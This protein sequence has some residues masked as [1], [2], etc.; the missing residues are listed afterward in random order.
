LFGK[1]MASNIHPIMWEYYNLAYQRRPEFMGWSQ[2][3]PTTKTNYSTF[4][5][6]NFGDE[7]QKRIHQ[8]QLIEYKVKALRKQIQAKDSDAFYQLVYYPVVGASYMNKKF[9]YRDKAYLYSKQNRLSALTYSAMSKVAYD[10]IVAETTYF[11]TQLR[12]GKWKHMMSMQPRKLPVFLEPELPVITMDRKA[13]WD[14]LP[15]GYD[16][17]YNPE[18]VNLKLPLFDNLNKQQY[19]I[20]LFLCDSITINWSAH[21][22]DPWIKVSTYS[23]ILNP[24]NGRSESRIWISV[25]W[26]KI[27]A[28]ELSKG[29]IYFE[30]HRKQW[31]YFY[32]AFFL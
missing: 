30:A 22:S 23:G 11:N 3:E 10:S 24:S 12:G 2:T 26:G 6:F 25:D 16:T 4:N 27:P 28:A 29:N 31:I 1:K 21:T 18:E 19:F 17:A 14:V 5:H 7:A 15:E 20:D 32:I 9:L 8:F 13:A